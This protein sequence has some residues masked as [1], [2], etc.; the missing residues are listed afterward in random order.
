MEGCLNRGWGPI[1]PGLP[2]LYTP[3]PISDRPVGL[4]FPHRAGRCRP[5]RS[6]FLR[7]GCRS[8]RGMEG[9]LNRGRG[10]ILSGLPSLYAPQ[11]ISDRPVELGFPHRAGRCRRGKSR[12]SSPGC[13]I[14]RHM[15]GFL[16]R[17]WDPTLPGCGGTGGDCLKGKLPPRAPRPLV[18]RGRAGGNPRPMGLGLG[19]RRD[20]SHMPI[21]LYHMTCISLV[22][23]MLYEPR[24]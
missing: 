17:G 16:N 3:Q 23:L 21:V 7:P 15:E 11:P 13:R 5:G 18:G 12:F 6:R 20:E 2:S 4:R 19:K 8:C 9:H 22:P 24:F 1:L 14:Y 10:P